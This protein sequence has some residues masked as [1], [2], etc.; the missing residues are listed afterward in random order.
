MDV[1]SGLEPANVFE[2]FQK[3]CA[4]P[5]GSTNEKALSDYCVKFA[6]ERSLEYYQDELYNVIII[7]EAS[8]GYADRP[9][10]IIQGHLDMV[11]EKE[12]DSTTDFEKD[13]IDLLI[14][15][16]YI[17]A[18]KTTLGGDDGIA[19]AYALALLD[20]DEIEHPKL[21]VVFTVCEELGMEGAQGID[22][23]MLSGRMLLN[24]DSEE[25]GCVITSCAG[26]CH[27]ECRLK[28]DFQKC[29]YNTLLD[30]EISGLTG[31]HSGCEIHKGR[32]NAN[33]VMGKLLL[34]LL[35]K[36]IDFGICQISGG[37]KDN[38]IPV[39]S[40]V[41]IGTS[42][43]DA[44]QKAVDEFQACARNEYG[45]TDPGMKLTAGECQ[46]G[47]HIYSKEQNVGDN[48]IKVL[49]AD[50]C[51][52]LIKLINALPNGV[53]KMSEDIDG[54]VETSLNFGIISMNDKE[55][56]LHYL[57]RSSKEAELDKLV[58]QM[59]KISEE[60]GAN[61][62]VSSRYP[63]WEYVQDS[64]LRQNMSDIYKRLYGKELRFESI[65]AGVECGILASKIK[66]LDGVSFGPDILDIHTPRERMS[67]ASVQRTW[68]FLLEIL[69]SL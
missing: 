52:S 69:K 19:I 1:I 61:T 65:H 27:V 45:M 26:G 28:A 59:K 6:K 50:S 42:D 56:V 57:P 55:A 14:T 41:I 16:G 39:N 13:G 46:D 48:D 8:K 38:A 33:I 12:D 43:A 37:K 17:H 5:H 53:I 30:I 66:D 15:D 21:E 58:S 29:E 23:S 64:K 22:L 31:G 60:F 4:I 54:M 3:I 40:S 35:E 44:V 62:E 9:T 51:K 2:Y 7:K 32:A 36:G 25:E 11:C 24:L 67:I 10:V 68:D 47:S 63:A 20:S 34:F 49:S 18:D